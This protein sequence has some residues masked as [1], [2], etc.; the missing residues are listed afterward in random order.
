M[1]TLSVI[2]TDSVSVFRQ[3]ETTASN[4]SG[5]GVCIRSIFPIF[6]RD[7]I[8]ALAAHSLAI[9]L[10]GSIGYC[11]LEHVTLVLV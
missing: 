11:R 9:S 6:Y 5:I 10:T 8:T 1:A 3:K 7:I 4:S 2:T